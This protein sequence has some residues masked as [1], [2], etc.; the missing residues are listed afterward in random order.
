MRLALDEQALPLQPD[1]ILITVIRQNF[2]RALRTVAYSG[3]LKPRFVR[4][5][6]GIRL[7]NT[8]LPEPP[9]GGQPYT[10]MPPEGGS[11]LL[12]KLGSLT[13]K[14]GRGLSGGGEA[15]HPRWLLGSAILRDA[16]RASEDAGVPLVVVLYPTPKGLAGKDPYRQLLNEEED[17]LVCDLYPAFEAAGASADDLFLPDG[18]PNPQGHAVAAQ[19]L[20]E[21]LRARGLLQ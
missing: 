19:G 17:L 14:I 13:D 7:V 10:D 12:W 21:F 18:H 1:L 15:A 8:P 3:Q 11:F 2:R 5:G 16:R 6:D 4:W 9:S 20:A